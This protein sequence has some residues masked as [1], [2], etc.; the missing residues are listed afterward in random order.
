MIYSGSSRS[1]SNLLQPYYTPARYSFYFKLVFLSKSYLRIF[2]DGK[3]E[4]S[5]DIS[6]SELSKQPLKVSRPDM[7]SILLMKSHSKLRLQSL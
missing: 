6:A 3:T 1:S 2:A 4:K 5:Y 7:Q